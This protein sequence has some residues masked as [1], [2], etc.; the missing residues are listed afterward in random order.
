MMA[1][2]ELAELVQLPSVA[3]LNVFAFMVRMIATTDAFLAYPR[4]GSS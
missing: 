1:V 3:A 4:I 2:R